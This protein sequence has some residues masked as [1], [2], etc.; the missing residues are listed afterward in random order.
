[1]STTTADNHHSPPLKMAAK[2]D[3]THLVIKYA[4]VSRLVLISLILLWRSLLS[5]YDTSASINPSCLSSI[6]GSNSKSGLPPVRLLR[7]ASAIE[8]SIV[9]DSVYFVRIAQCGYE[10]EQ[11]Y[12]FLPLLPVCISLLSRTVFAPLIPFIGQRAVLGLSGYVLNN[13][14]FVLAAFYLYRLSAIIL[15]DSE[16]ALRASI[17]FCLNPASIFYSSIYTESM[18]ALCTI[19]G[20]YYL[21]RGSNNIATLWLAL[22]GFA[23]SNGVLNA[24][25]ICF[26]TMH[27]SYKAAFVRKHAGVTVLVLLFGALRSLF[28][29][30]PFIAFQAY[31]YYNMCVG[32]TSDEMRPWCKARLPLLYNYI[33]SRYWGVGF[34]KYFQVKQIPN[35]VLASPILSLALCTIIH[36]VK[37]WPEVFVSLGFRA[38]SPNKESVGSSIPL[39]RSAGSKNVGFPSEN[40]SDAGQGDSLRQRKPAVREENY[41]VQPSEDE[42]SEISG[43]K[44][45]IVVPFILH[46]V[47][48]A[49]T[50]F[51]V[52]H[53]QVSTRFLSASPPL[54]WFG[55]YVMASPC[56]SKRWGYIIWAYCAAYI[57]LGSFFSNFYPFT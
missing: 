51:F 36:Y 14:S 30:F 54:Y 28:I 33:Q 5:P 53:V 44:P 42:P 41:V 8:D 49:A 16:L 46:L 2:S 11:T 26:Q 47:F 12:A 27:R 1:M 39:G 17:L 29:I 52:M 7:L 45:V 15:K 23:R 9:W 31:G 22:S 57:L 40:R 43:I 24:G 38:S 10:Y 13:L 19:G 32:G 21:M 20:L 34:L 18:Y 50:A 35:F 3:Y 55:S 4:V 37:L 25:Y 48:M 56:L 6:N